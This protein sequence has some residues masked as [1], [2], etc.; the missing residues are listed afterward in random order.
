MNTY[1][2][3]DGAPI[4]LEDLGLIGITQTAFGR[5]P[6]H[7][8]SMG[9]CMQAAVATALGFRL[10]EVPHFVAGGEDWW[11]RMNAWLTRNAGLVLLG[12]AAGD[13]TVPPVLHLTQG[14]TVRDSQHVVVSFG[15]Q[16]VWDPH[17]SRAGLAE[18]LHQEFFL[19]VQPSLK[20]LPT[21]ELRRQLALR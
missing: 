3:R 14:R 5:G 11:D 13:W 2:A 20:P 7:G 18:V 4:T 8:E 21:V 9:N 12:T 6:D 16:M 1:A 17:P 19:A 10:E 15:G